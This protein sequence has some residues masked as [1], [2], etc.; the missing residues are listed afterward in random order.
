ML[1]GG[2]PDGS[3]IKGKLDKKTGVIMFATSKSKT[4]ESLEEPEEA[5]AHEE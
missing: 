4:G 1:R 2:F 5:E 3:V